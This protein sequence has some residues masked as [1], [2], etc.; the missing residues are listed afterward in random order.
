[1]IVIKYVKELAKQEKIA[2]KLNVNFYFCKP[3][4]SWEHVAMKTQTGLL[5]NISQNICTLV[6]LLKKI[7]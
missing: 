1:L 4:H 7:R 2:R 6:S 3:Y 5:G